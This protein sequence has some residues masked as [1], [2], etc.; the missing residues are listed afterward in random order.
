MY[1]VVASF[2]SAIALLSDGNKYCSKE[3]SNKRNE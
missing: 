2:W 1:A 3:E